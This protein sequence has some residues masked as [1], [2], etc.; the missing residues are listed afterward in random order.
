MVISLPLTR[1]KLFVR[2]IDSDNGKVFCWSLQKQG[3]LLD[4]FPPF[5]WRK[6]IFRHST[7]QTKIGGNQSQPEHGNP[8]FG[9]KSNNLRRFF[10]S[11]LTWKVL[12]SISVI[13]SSFILC[14]INRRWTR[15]IQIW[16]S[17]GRIWSQTARTTETIEV[18]LKLRAKTLERPRKPHTPHHYPSH[19]H[20]PHLT[21][22]QVEV[23]KNPR[24]NQNNNNNKQTNR[25]SSSFLG[26]E[27]FQTVHFTSF[28]TDSSAG[29][30]THT[31]LPWPDKAIFFQ[32]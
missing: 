12:D 1:H 7:S 21:R 4:R 3:Q 20:T 2:C 26:A 23:V 24:P 18:F 32:A 22:H 27:T 30:H 8:V 29:T 10:G 15:F 5:W 28:D 11:L 25:V 13:Q 14:N 9:C 31:P 17:V 16:H 6:T 19:D